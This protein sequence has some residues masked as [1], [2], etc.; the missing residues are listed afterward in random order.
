LFP[1]DERSE[2]QVKLST[3]ASPN[4]GNIFEL[5]LGSFK[6]IVRRSQERNVAIGTPFLNAKSASPEA[7]QMKSSAL[8][9]SI[10]VLTRVRLWTVHDL[11]VEQALLREGANLR[12]R[13]Q[14]FP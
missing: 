9:I 12:T 13:E 7:V 1:S 10:S 8:S 4:F 6:L 2:S 3:G 5:H 11:A 14:E